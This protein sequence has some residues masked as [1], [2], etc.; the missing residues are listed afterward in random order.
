MNDDNGTGLKTSPTPQTQNSEARDINLNNETV[1]QI[2][3]IHENV[4]ELK[5]DMKEVKEFI[6]SIKEGYEVEEPHII[7]SLIKAE[8]RKLN[9]LENQ[10]E[11]TNEVINSLEGQLKPIHPILEQ[12][13]RASNKTELRASIIA[14]AI[15]ESNRLYHKIPQ[16]IR[17]HNKLVKENPDLVEKISSKN[18]KPRNVKIEGKQSSKRVLTHRSVKKMKELSEEGII[19]KEFQED[20]NKE[21]HTVLFIPR[22]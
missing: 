10:V 3:E 12:S 20:N 4:Q 15:Y 8:K 17:L 18:T 5:Q 11:T 19:K 22:D 6:K 21:G 1:N 9:W 13:W 16:I 7:K 14:I 2:R